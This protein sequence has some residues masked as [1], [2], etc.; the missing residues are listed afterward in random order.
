MSR[1]N[2]SGPVPVPVCYLCCTCACC[3]ARTRAC[4]V[5][6][7]VNAFGSIS[8]LHSTTDNPHPRNQSS[9]HR[10]PLNIAS[11]PVPFLLISHPMIVGLALPKLLARATQQPVASRA[12]TPFSD[13]SNRLGE[14]RGQQKQVDMI[15]H[16]HERSEMILAQFLTA[17]QRFDNERCDRFS[18]QI[19][20]DRC[21]L[22]PD[23]DPPT[24]KLR[25]RRL[26]GL[27]ENGSSASC[28]ADAR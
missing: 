8:D 12:V 24:R 17:Q 23:N 27:A 26:C 15:R 11:D 4:R 6:T 10:I 18:S 21:A 1:K 7:R 3:G 25:H 28:R 13:F 2:S 14:I 9:L 16:D 22:H 5:H 20:R 19:A